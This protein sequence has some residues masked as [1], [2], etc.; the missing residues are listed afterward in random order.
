MRVRSSAGR[1][2][3]IVLPAAAMAVL[4]ASPGAAH[5]DTDMTLVVDSVAEAGYYVDSGARYFKS[6]GALDLLRDNKARHSPLFVAVLPAGESPDAVLNG[7]MQG[8][9]RKG[10]YAVISG[11]TLRIKSN[12]LPKSQVKTAY[13]KA[14]AANAS[15]PDK[16][17]ISFVKLLPAAADLPEKKRE[18]R[19]SPPQPPLSET[20]VGE[21]KQLAREQAEAAKR[22]AAQEAAQDGGLPVLPVAGGVVLVLLAGGGFLLWRRRNTAPAAVAAGS[23]TAVAQGRPSGS[24]APGPGPGTPGASGPA[25]G[26]PQQP[27]GD[28]KGGQSRGA[29]GRGQPPGS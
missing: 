11:N 4:L 27:S 21:D 25:A 9:K 12:A 5:A 1:R 24:A 19:E 22:R 6:D 3:P 8:V 14:V 16:A 28:S 17:L 18:T 10:T 26:G 23:E 15:R 2:L 13:D 29:S 20:N 7:L